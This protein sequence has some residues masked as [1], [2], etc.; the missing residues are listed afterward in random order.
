M[1]SGS[2]LQAA[3]AIIAAVVAASR[4]D[5]ARLRGCVDALRGLSW[6]LARR[7]VVPPPIEQHISMVERTHRA[8]ARR[9]P[10]RA[11][12]GARRWTRRSRDQL[13]RRPGHGRED[14]EVERARDR[15][16]SRLEDDRRRLGV[17]LG[18]RHYRHFLRRPTR[19]LTGRGDPLPHRSQARR[20]GRIAHAPSVLDSRQGAKM[21]RTTEMTEEPYVGRSPFLGAFA[22][23]RE[24]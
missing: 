7:R 22:P 13:G 2:L 17:A 9:G 6:V 1:T 15:A 8:S 12:S 14:R 10:S 23:W 11:S 16:G 3:S 5:R 21:Q 18:D 24:S 20:Q 4:D 19:P